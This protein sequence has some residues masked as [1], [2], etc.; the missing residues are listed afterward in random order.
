MKDVSACDCNSLHSVG[1]FHGWDDF[2]YFVQLLK[3]SSEF[4]EVPVLRPYSKVGLTESW[5]QCLR[6]EQVWRLVSPDPPF[7]GLW[8]PVS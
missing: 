2:N 3:S 5:H 6:C 7:T 8:E 1:K 4:K